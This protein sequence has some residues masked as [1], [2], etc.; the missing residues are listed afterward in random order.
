MKKLCD[1]FGSVPSRLQPSGTSVE[2]TKFFFLQLGA[3]SEDEKRTCSLFILLLLFKVS[4]VVMLL[5]FENRGRKNAVDRI[6]LT[7]R[8]HDGFISHVHVQ[9]AH[10]KNAEWGGSFRKKNPGRRLD[11]PSANQIS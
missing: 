3:E 10:R 1:V 9:R 7:T 8:W 4:G 6:S 11:K 2:S 5:M